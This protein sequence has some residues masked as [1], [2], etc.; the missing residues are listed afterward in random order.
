LLAQTRLKAL[1]APG[2]Y[3]QLAD[4]SAVSDRPDTEFVREL[5]ARIGVAAIPISVFSADPRPERLIRFCFAKDEATLDAAG[6]RLRQ[7]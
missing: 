2:T 7:L 1:P 4:Y 3:F 5:T 6:V